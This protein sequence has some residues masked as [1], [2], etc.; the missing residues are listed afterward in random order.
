M[1]NT[2]ENTKIILF[3]SL[4]VAMILPFGNIIPAHSEVATIEDTRMVNELQ[5]IISNIGKTVQKKTLE[6][7]TKLKLNTVVKQLDDNVY[8]V[9][10]YAVTKPTDGEKIVSEKIK[11]TIVRESDG[12]MT[13][14]TTT[15]TTKF[16]R[17]S[18]ATGMVVNEGRTQT[19]VIAHDRGYL[20]DEPNEGI[21]LHDKEGTCHAH[22]HKVFGSVYSDG[23]SSLTW[24]VHG[25]VIAYC[26]VPQPLN[27]VTMQLNSL[28][29]NPPT[30]TTGYWTPTHSFGDDDLDPCF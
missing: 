8:K 1:Y 14:S 28:Q 12:S 23:T 11:Y 9:K 3:A 21:F 5:S 4:I 30:S 18:G 17:S 6:D 22:K 27:D 16:T 19:T 15:G 7:G 25:W 2:L 13:V 10:T 29:I 26:I 20:D 24:H